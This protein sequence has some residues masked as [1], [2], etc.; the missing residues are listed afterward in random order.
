MMTEKDFPDAGFDTVQLV[1][2][3]QAREALS[4]LKNELG[5]NVLVD[6]TAAD[7]SKWPEAKEG[8]FELTWRLMKLDP[9]TGLVERRLALK[10]RVAE[11]EDGPPSS[12]DLWPNA[13]WAEREVWDMFGVKPSDNPS[14]KRLLLYE[15]FKGHPL[16][17]DYPIAKRQPLV[18]PMAAPRE[19]IDPKEL[20][21]KLVDS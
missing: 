2:K 9:K 12:K 4:F 20:R 3:A 6:H 5:F 13:D 16:R 15:E 1:P 10:T 18:E 19:R 21:P 8:R 17:K 14:I 11:G 7:L